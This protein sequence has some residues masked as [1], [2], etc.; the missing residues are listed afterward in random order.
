MHVCTVTIYIVQTFISISSSMILYG[1][2]LVTYQPCVLVH[3]VMLA[4]HN[5]YL[6]EY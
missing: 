6:N 4:V 3:E 2:D 5:K 1:L